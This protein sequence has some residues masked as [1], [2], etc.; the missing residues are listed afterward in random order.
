MNDVA[1]TPPDPARTGA[2]D[3]RELGEVFGAHANRLRRM[4]EF[5]LDRRLRGRIEADDILQEVYLAARQRMAH[6]PADGSPEAM[7]IWLRQVALQTLI[8]LH[9]R[10]FGA[11]MRSVSREIS[12][13]SGSAS[14]STSELIAVEL[15]AHMTTP[16][17]VS[18]REE[19]LK[20]LEEALEGMN[21]VDRE[22]LALRHYEELSNSEVAQ[23]LGISQTAASNRYVRALARLKEVLTRIPGFDEHEFDS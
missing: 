12:L 19:T 10:H 16:S 4:V 13:F 15:S 23:V 2:A 17:H 18:M 5:R 22:I 9:R 3:D 7:F 8:D 21:E 14:P 1:A 11:Q 6:S 20:Q